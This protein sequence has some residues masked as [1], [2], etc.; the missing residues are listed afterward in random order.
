MLVT[1][2]EWT[3][4]TQAPKWAK[5]VAQIIWDAKPRFINSARIEELLGR[6]SIT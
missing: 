2:E 6:L 1:F 3:D 4:H 5:P